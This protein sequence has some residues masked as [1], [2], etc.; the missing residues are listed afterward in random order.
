M[1][2]DDQLTVRAAAS[3]LDATAPAG[4]VRARELVRRIRWVDG[5]QGAGPL[6]VRALLSCT[7]TGSVRQAMRAVDPAAP[8][9]GVRAAYAR[10]GYPLGGGATELPRHPLSLRDAARRVIGP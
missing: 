3:A 10:L 2:A 5:R 4:G 6:S 8:P 1:P 9:T 7:R